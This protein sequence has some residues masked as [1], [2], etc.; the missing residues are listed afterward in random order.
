MLNDL[1]DL[2]VGGICVYL[3]TTLPQPSF[4]AGVLT[5]IGIALI[6]AIAAEAL[7]S[8]FG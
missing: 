5:F 2:L 7:T 6:A 3:G 4:G 8:R 1:H